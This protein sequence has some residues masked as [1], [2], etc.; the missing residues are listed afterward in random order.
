MLFMT[1][2]NCQPNINRFEPLIAYDMETYYGNLR[3]VDQKDILHLVN[4]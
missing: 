4:W 2:L 1:P 3:A